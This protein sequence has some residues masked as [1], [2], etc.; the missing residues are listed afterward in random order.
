MNVLIIE[1]DNEVAEYVEEVILN[2]AGL[3]SATVA[4]AATGDQ[5]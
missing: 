5:V 3:E 4:R 1:D 2:T